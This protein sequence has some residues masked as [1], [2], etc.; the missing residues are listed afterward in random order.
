MLANSSSHTAATTTSPA[1]PQPHGLGAG[2]QRGGRAALH[3]EAAAAVEA[4]ALDARLERPLVAVVPDGVGVPVEQQRAP[5][6]AAARDA[7]HVG[8]AGRDL[9]D[10][11]L[12]ARRARA[13][14]R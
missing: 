8:A 3:V 11:R 4:V 1:R 12:D 7:D 14:R 10:A 5:A 13:S 9:V 2:P 6:A